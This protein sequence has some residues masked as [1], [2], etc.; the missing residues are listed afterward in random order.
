MFQIGV[1]L[2][3]FRH[4]IKIGGLTLERKTGVPGCVHIQ[5]ISMRLLFLQKFLLELRVYCSDAPKIIET[6]HVGN[7][8]G[9]PR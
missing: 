8:Y 1:N 7:V 4:M 5:I 6:S 2:L 3:L 9:S